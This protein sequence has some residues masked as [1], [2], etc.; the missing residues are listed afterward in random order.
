[1]KALA[2]NSRHAKHLQE[3]VQHD[4]SPSE[5]STH[6]M[7]TPEPDAAAQTAIV[8]ADKLPSQLLQQFGLGLNLDAAQKQAA[9]EELVLAVADA[10]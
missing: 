10:G 1:M 2:C 4:A 7:H 8:V 9:L 5:A 3:V 6:A